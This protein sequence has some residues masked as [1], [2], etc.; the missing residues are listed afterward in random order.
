MQLKNVNKLLIVRLSSL[1]DILLTTPLI[2]SIKQKYPSVKI[3]FVLSEEYRDLLKLNPHLKNVFLYPHHKNKIKLLKEHICNN[4]YDLILDLQNNIR[5][6]G[7]LRCY[8]S[9]TVGFEKKHFDKFLL[10]NF[11]I[12]RLKDSMQVAER[13]ASTLENFEL[14]EKGPELITDKLA[15]SAILGIDNLVGICPGS[16]HFTKMWPEENYIQLGKLLERNGYTVVLLG[17]QD[18]KQICLSIV[19]NLTSAI[20]LSNDNDIL[21]T[22]ADMKMC[23]A[24]YCNDSGLMHTA[25]AIGVPVIAFFGST[26][27]EF[28]FA[29][30]NS[31][32]IILENNS[33]SCRPCTHIG[34]SNC[35]KKHFKCMKE[36]SAELAFTQ[37]ELIKTQ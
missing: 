9:S 16:K 29:P 2:R 14:D 5:S 20:N 21:Q 34:R 35:P 7:L 4:N 13:Y 22:A 31:V 18:D 3:D 33:L 11:K 24:I 12:N 15:N 32:N 6:S 37:L 23:E 10:V 36:I 1:G 30:Y 25:T 28:G 19:S 26:V 17:G 8:G 27:R